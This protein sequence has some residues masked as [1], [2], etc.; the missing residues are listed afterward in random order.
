M[1]A[2]ATQRLALSLIFAAACAS[3]QAHPAAPASTPAARATGN[4]DA[5]AHGLQIKLTTVYVDDQAKA[6]KFYTD[7]VGFAAKDDFS[8]GGFRWLTVSSPAAPDGGQLQLA[9]NT[10]PAGKAYQQALF[11]QHQPA[12]M[13]YTDDLKADYERIK[14]HGGAFTMPPTAVTNS[15]IAVLDDTCGNLIQLTQLER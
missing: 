8:N 1:R 2:L 13:L 7:V 9:L 3:S 4:P 12:V 10:N 14:A 6:L 11:Q 5:P 15:T